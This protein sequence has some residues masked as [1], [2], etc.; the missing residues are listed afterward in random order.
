MEKEKTFEKFFMYNINV[1]DKDSIKRIQDDA[2][3]LALS[4]RVY[5]SALWT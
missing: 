1:L 2:E 3:V 5:S 4:E